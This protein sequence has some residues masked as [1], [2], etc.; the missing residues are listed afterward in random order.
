MIDI[1]AYLETGIVESHCLG[2]AS[3]EE[4]E[5]LLALCQ[6][7]PLIKEE[8]VRTELAL[9]IYAKSFK[10]ELQTERS[11]TI[12]SNILE[13]IQFEDLELKNDGTLNKF[14]DI[15]NCS[16]LEKL[17]AILSPLQAPEDFE[18]V[19][20]EVI[21]SDGAKELNLVWVKDL[22]PMEEHPHLDESFLVL[23]GTANCNIDGVITKMKRGDYMRIPPESHHE[24][25]ITS[26]TRAKAIQSRIALAT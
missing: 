15:S 26:S 23:E 4:S 24:V 22:V 17:E 9:E 12:K 3:P 1:K 7:Y 16:N 5:E 11:K 18:S 21:F 13:A 14:I 25:V 10:K 2:L 6:Q 19:H 8:L 20:M